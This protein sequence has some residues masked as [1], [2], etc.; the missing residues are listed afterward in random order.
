F[1]MGQRHNLAVKRVIGEDGK[2]THEAGK[3]AG[4]DRFAARKQIVDDLRELGLLI[5]EEP[6]KNRVGGCQRCGPLVEPLIPRQWFVKT[7]PLATPALDAVRTGRTRFVPKHWE[8][9]YY[10][11]MENIRDWCISRQLWWGHRIPAWTCTNGHLT[12]AREDP[13]S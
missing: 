4:L 1:D 13:P 10:A 5:K 11:W 3:Y 8:N 9:T 7:E 6:Y 12:V 2:M